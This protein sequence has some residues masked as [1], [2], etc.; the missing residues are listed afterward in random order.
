[1]KNF[2]R[3]YAKTRL[4]RAAAIQNRVLKSLA[5][6][7]GMNQQEAQSLATKRLPE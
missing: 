3:G 2:L 1:M 5:G 4:M 6:L 7:T